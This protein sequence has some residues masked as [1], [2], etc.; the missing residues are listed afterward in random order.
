MILLAIGEDLQDIGRNADRRV[1]LRR[2]RSV[3]PQFELETQ[4]P[5]RFLMSVA[6]VL[7]NLDRALKGLARVKPV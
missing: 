1:V 2:R 6:Q 4:L 5:F 7:G 3:L